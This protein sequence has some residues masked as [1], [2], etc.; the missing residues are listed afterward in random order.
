[1]Q[2]RILKVLEFNKIK[3]HLLEH[4][5]SSLGKRKTE[6]LYPSSDFNEV[7][8][9]QEETDE[10]VKVLRIKGNV[11][12]GGIFDIRHHVKRAEIGGMLSPHEL[13]EI[14]STIHAS[15]QIKRFIEEFNDEESR[16]P[17]L[18]SYMERII[19]LADL[20]T[21]IKNAI[22][23]NGEVLDLSLIHI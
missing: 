1:M 13:N 11:P 3:E 12:L 22:D 4:V 8:C 17:I 18:L 21:V 23:D 15:R 6:N 16:L 9:W 10:A 5:S 14:S 20:E 2:E 19:V 7:V